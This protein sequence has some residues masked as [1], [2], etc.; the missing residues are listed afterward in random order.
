M[1]I[2]RYNDLYKDRMS[3]FN[4]YLLFT[5]FVV[6]LSL[7]V[8]MNITYK[9][10]YLAKAVVD[11]NEYLKCLIEENSLSLLNKNSTL[12]IDG[13]EYQYSILSVEPIVN[14]NNLIYQ[15]ELKVNLDSKISKENNVLNLKILVEKQSVLKYVIRKVGEIY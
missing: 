6:L 1:D 7:F 15:V 14:E 4:S 12:I 13:V 10:Y 11:N 2:I 9:K 5:V 3:I 8:S